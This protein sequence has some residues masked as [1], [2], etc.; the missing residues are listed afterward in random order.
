MSINFYRNVDDV[1]KSNDLK[2]LYLKFSGITFSNHLT[3]DLFMETFI[4][5][6]RFLLACSARPECD[7]AS[8]G[9]ALNR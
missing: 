8:L 1:K 4:L 5:T 2:M 6:F 7:C 3:F 9:H